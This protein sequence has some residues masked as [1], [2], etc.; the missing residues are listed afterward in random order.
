MAG[1]HYFASGHPTNQSLLTSS[2]TVL[3]GWKLP[4]S[5]VSWN[6]AFSV[7][8]LFSMP[9]TLK[10]HLLAEALHTKS[11]I[12]VLELQWLYVQNQDY[13]NESPKDSTH[14]YTF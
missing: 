8:V 7:P 6:T 1:K 10:S 14:S 11:L 9:T 5:S 13:E 2:C 12:A 3:C 4:F